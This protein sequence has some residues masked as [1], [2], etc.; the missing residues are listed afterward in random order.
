MSPRSPPGVA[1]RISDR[2]WLNEAAGES[3]VACILSQDLS[4]DAFPVPIA[5]QM[6]SP[7]LRGASRAGSSAHCQPLYQRFRP[8]NDIA[9]TPKATLLLGLRPGSKQ[10]D[11]VV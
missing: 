11:K 2:P 9:G 1:G 8:H 3:A 10:K 6:R 7:S 4:R 5:A